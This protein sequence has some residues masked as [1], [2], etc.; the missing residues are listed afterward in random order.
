[1]QP[2]KFGFGQPVL[3]K[4][5]DALIRG[6]GRYVGDVTPEG[7]LHAV[8]LRSPHAHARFRIADVAA[9]RALP[10]VRLI[11]T[12][13]DLAG[14]AP[15]PCVAG[16]PNV[17]IEAPPY[18]VLARGEAFHVATRSPSWWPRRRSRRR[19]RPRRSR[20]SGRRCRTRW[21]RSRP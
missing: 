4:E 5:D 9:A 12:G 13:E 17:K 20:S 19:T 15:M 8:V 18:H 14:I 1:M 16:I 21:T 7:T 2:M 10:G 11:L 6:A 3:R